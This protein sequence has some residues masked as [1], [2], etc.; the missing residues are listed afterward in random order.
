MKDPLQLGSQKRLNAA[1]QLIGTGYSCL[2]R[3]TCVA[4]EVENYSKYKN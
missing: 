1:L 3:F 4:L 2:V